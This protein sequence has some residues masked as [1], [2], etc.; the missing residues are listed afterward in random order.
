MSCENGPFDRCWQ[1][2]LQTTTLSILLWKKVLLTCPLLV[3]MD[4]QADLELNC[5]HMSKGSFL[6]GHVTNVELGL[7]SHKLLK[8]TQS[9][10]LKFW[11]GLRYDIVWLCSFSLP[12]LN[13]NRRPM[14]LLISWNIFMVYHSYILRGYTF[15]DVDQ[16]WCFFLQFLV[17]FLFFH[18]LTCIDSC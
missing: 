13:V 3:L 16:Q 14:F 18:F 9:I 2:S 1:W 15:L 6:A 17:H 10:T 12:A 4:A 5:P 7:C 11:N 8:S